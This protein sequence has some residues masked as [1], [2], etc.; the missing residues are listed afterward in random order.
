MKKDWTPQKLYELL[1]E[2]VIG[3]DDYIKTL[4]TTIWLHHIRIETANSFY[5]S[6]A[7]PQKQNLLVIGPTGSGKTLAIQT[8]ADL[9]GYDLLITNAPDFTGTGW[10]G[11]D[12][13]E[14]V[15]DLF[16]QCHESVERTEKG[17]IFLDEIDKIVES[18]HEKE[19]YR[20]FGVENS[21]LKLVEGTEVRM[22]DHG[23]MVH[24][25]NMLFIAAGAF[26]GIEDVISKRV[27]EGK[28]MGF[29]ATLLPSEKEADL[30]LQ[31][32]KQ[33]LMEYGVGAQFLGR[34]SGLAALRELKVEDITDI[35]LHSRASVVKGLDAML[36]RSIGVGV[37]I[38]E[39]GARAVAEQA[40]DEKTGARGAAFLIQ[41]VM[42]DILFLI[43]EEENVASI[44]IFANEDGEP[45]VRLIEGEVKPSIN[46]SAPD[47]HVL[48]I[49][50]ITAKDKVHSV[51]RYVDHLLNQKAMTVC[52][53]RE[54]RAAHLLVSSMV[55]YLFEECNPDDHTT[56]GLKK[57]LGCAR[58]DR[59]SP[60]EQ[61]VA[62]CLIEREDPNREYRKLYREYRGLHTGDRVIDAVI[63]SIEEFE[64]R[65]SYQAM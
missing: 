55:L 8:L 22:S 42:K 59:L 64:K 54:R 10:K 2:T 6:E 33:D 9:L 37:T 16:K 46:V 60:E 20:T 49:V 36:R 5:R 58:S 50:R 12:V 45:A 28:Q 51:V 21:L 18:K 61:S 63:R 39:T 19:E 27:H 52:S 62:A 15:I 26:D 35:L 24:T 13:S 25:K 29:H 41:E 30:R 53:T 4:S 48:D 57:L 17:I 14:M 7:A 56:A 11:R 32:K 40:V 31:V 43:A 23:P 65:P 3:Q 38:D 47:F 44:S 1:K 34:F